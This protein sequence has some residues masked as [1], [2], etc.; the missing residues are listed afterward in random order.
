[1]LEMHS[2]QRRPA[3]HAMSESDGS[4]EMSDLASPD[5]EAEPAPSRPKAKPSRAPGTSSSRSR[6]ESERFVAEMSATVPV[7]SFGQYTGMTYQ[8]VALKH[9]D[10]YFWASKQKGPS[11]FLI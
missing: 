3:R 7:V 10:Y 6:A 1:M 2:V 8:E 11:N 9:P 5:S 4:E